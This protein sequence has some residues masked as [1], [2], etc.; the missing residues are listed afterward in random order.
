M[1][2]FITR[3]I[4]KDC[5]RMILA[6]NAAVQVVVARNQDNGVKFTD[7]PAN[8]AI[9]SGRCCEPGIH[10]PDKQKPNLWFYHYAYNVSDDGNAELFDNAGA[11]GMAG[12]LSQAHIA[13]KYQTIR[14]FTDIIYASLILK[15][16][17]LRFHGPGKTSSALASSLSILRLITIRISRTLS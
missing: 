14:S 17:I 15:L 8:G 3:E 4:R 2:N 16:G 11:K 12:L 1:E 10:E 6:T 9:D 7:I 13:A 5:N